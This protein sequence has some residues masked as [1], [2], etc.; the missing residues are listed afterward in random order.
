[1]IQLSFTVTWPALLHKGGSDWNEKPL[2]RLKTMA[3]WEDRGT[4]RGAV[5][6]VNHYLEDLLRMATSLAEY[7]FRNQPLVRELVSL[8]NNGVREFWM[9]LRNFVASFFQELTQ[10]S[11]ASEQ[12]AWDVIRDMMSSVFKQIR[13]AR[14]VAQSVAS[15]FPMHTVAERVEQ[16]ALIIWGTVQAHRVMEELMQAK[17]KGH[18]CVVVPSLMFLLNHRAPTQMVTDLQARVDADEKKR[19][20]MNRKIHKMN[21]MIERLEKKCERTMAATEIQSQND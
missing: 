16:A 21:C 10:G 6:E 1:M 2:N 15:T 3:D 13:E 17:F 18:P 20:E 11:K 9:E 19:N 7:K 12:E 5:L 4:R 8:L 14:S